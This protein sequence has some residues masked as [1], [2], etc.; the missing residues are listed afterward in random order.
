MNIVFWL[1][2]KLSNETEREL[3]TARKYQSIRHTATKLFYG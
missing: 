1:T 2:V 3:N